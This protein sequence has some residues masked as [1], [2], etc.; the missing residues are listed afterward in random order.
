MWTLRNG[1]SPMPTSRK[2]KAAIISTLP[3]HVTG[4][5]YELGCG[6]GTL[7]FPLASRYPGVRVIGIET[8]PVPF[9]VS[10]VLAM[11][12]QETIQVVRRDIFQQDLSDAGLVVC[13]L[14]PAAMS[15]LKAKFEAELKP[16]AW[17]VS[18]TFAVPFWK[19]VHEVKV[20][21]L[22]HTTIYVYRMKL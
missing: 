7:L 2:V 22:Y 1:I 13:Y 9:L 15:K 19:A 6:W 17:V 10:K 12:K 5:I 18:H 16:G 21:D 11:G 3:L 8:S 14:Y 20:D 4:V